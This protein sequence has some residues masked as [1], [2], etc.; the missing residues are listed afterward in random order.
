MQQII[1]LDFKGE[2]VDEILIDGKPCEVVHDGCFLYFPTIFFQTKN[3]KHKIE[4]RFSNSYAN[5]GYGLHSFVD[6]DKKQYVYSD[7]EYQ[8][9][10]NY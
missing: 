2:T 3:T 8:F 7:L 4:I 9:S 5:D 10:I 1:F 6:I